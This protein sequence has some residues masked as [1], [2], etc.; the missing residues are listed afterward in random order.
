MVN[1]AM[2]RYRRCSEAIEEDR[3]HRSRTPGVVFAESSL[4]AQRHRSSPA[5][6][7]QDMSMMIQTPDS[8]KRRPPG[9]LIEQS[10]KDESSEPF[11]EI[12]TE[13]EEDL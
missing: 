9:L 13:G 8:L 7:T 10:K 1:T 2:C 4:K 3:I 6:A 11:V 12:Q 5:R